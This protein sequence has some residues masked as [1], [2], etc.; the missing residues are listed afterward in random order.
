MSAPPS[1]QADAITFPRMLAT[2]LEVL[3]GLA[4]AYALLVVL[5]W[6]FQD[7]IAFPAP[8]ARLPD[9]AALG[10]DGTRV[11]VP[12]SDGIT[13]RG[14]YF[15]PSEGSRNAAGGLLWFHGNMETVAGLA[16]VFR[17]VRPTNRGVLALD[18]RGYGESGGRPTEEGLYRDGDAAW[19]FLAARPEI[20]A[21]RIAVYGRSLGSAVALAVATTH[22]VCAV[23]LDSPFTSAR[24]MTRAHFWFLPPSLLRQRLDNVARA[25]TLDA[26][27]MVIH[28]TA[29]KLAPIA[30]GRA[31]AAAGRA[32]EFLAIEGAEH[33]ET[34][35]F[36]GAR[37]RDAVRTFLDRTCT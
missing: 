26:P 22:P 17:A 16:D 5:A 1:N 12:T 6:T 33:N 10:L 37:Y 8:R 36:A 35:A 24:A 29:D 4:L 34:Y 11:E 30:M 14:W 2:T 32:S 9:L 15:A 28:G 19:A 23:V 25:A 3:G 7:R 13:L 31:V 18:Y 20:D 27:L 21:A